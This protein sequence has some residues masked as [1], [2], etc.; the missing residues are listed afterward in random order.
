MSVF[1]R[2]SYTTNV[3]YSYTQREELKI[4][5]R[6]NLNVNF[7][8]LVSDVSR[9]T[10]VLTPF[11]LSTAFVLL[12]SLL[13]LNISLCNSSNFK[14]LYEPERKFIVTASE[15][16]V[17]S[18]HF[19]SNKEVLIKGESNLLKPNLWSRLMYIWFPL[20]SYIL[21]VK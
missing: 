12:L 6:F 16:S 8:F 18:V 1:E 7:K 21:L 2:T 13:L 14:K 11:P 19:C 20:C 4:L 17:L 5:G 10:S 15:I 9:S 3:G